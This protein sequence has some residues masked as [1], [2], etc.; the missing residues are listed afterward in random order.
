MRSE[1]ALGDAE[2]TSGQRLEVLGEDRKWVGGS[3]YSPKSELETRK[4]LI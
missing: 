2:K 4:A 1:G 3:P